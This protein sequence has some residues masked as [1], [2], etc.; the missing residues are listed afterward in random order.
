MSFP[1][2]VRWD[3][4]DIFFEKE[5]QR[6]AWPDGTRETS[7]CMHNFKFSEDNFNDSFKVLFLGYSIS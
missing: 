1:G 2:H 5:I 7:N 4:S 3:C 6:K